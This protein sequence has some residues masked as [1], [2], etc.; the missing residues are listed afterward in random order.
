MIIK[1]GKLYGAQWIGADISPNQIAQAKKLSEAANYNI[2]YVVA[3]AE[4]F[5]LPPKSLD[6]VTA[7]QCFM[8]FDKA[9]ALPRIHRALKKDGHFVI[10]FMAWLPSES[11]IAL[12]SE[13]LVLKYNPLW[14]GANMK[15]QKVTA[16]E[17]LGDNF[18]VAATLAYD[19]DLTFTRESWHG[20][21]KA[22]RGIGA[23]SLP[24]TS[25]ADWEKEHLAYLSTVPKVF[26]I[27]HYVMVL[28]LKKKAHAYRA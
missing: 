27:P 4:N 11:P 21:M 22:C 7:C 23:S 24:P 15:R 1:K 26:E 8:Y 19:V 13:N 28:D 6:A 5:D 18:E 10:L 9:A 3:S 20:R 17:W 14:T 2:D 25:I 16:P 12:A